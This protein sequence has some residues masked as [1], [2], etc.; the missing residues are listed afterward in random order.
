MH[1]VQK[2]TGRLPE[3]LVNSNENYRGYNFHVIANVFE[4]FRK[5]SENIKF[6]ENLQ[7]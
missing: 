6:P 2:I 3:I 4:N 1:Y 7:L 5:I